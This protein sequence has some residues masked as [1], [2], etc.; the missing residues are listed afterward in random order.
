MSTLRISLRAYSDRH[1]VEWSLSIYVQ[2]ISQ[3]HGG[4]SSDKTL[5]ERRICEEQTPQRS[6]RI[7]CGPRGGV[8]PTRSP[9]SSGLKFHGDVTDNSGTETK[10]AKSLEQTLPY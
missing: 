2:H 9:L 8:G 3:M 10:V 6:I 7:L 1:P 5:C 4:Q